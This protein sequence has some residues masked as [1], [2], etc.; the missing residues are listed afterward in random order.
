MTPYTVQMLAIHDTFD[1]KD[2]KIDIPDANNQPWGALMLVL[3]AVCLTFLSY[4]AC[5]PLTLLQVEHAL[6][7]WETGNPKGVLLG[8]FDKATW[9]TTNKADADI[10]AITEMEDSEWSAIVRAVYAYKQ[11]V[12]EGAQAQ[13]AKGKG[14]AA[15]ATLRSRKAPG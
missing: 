8:S 3:A 4:N 5:L 13:T 12:D 14:K 2:M 11:P 10:Q 9:C 1:Y 6:Q 7:Q 15:R